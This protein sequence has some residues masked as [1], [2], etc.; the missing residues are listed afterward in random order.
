[1]INNPY[2][3]HKNGSRKF[4][5]EILICKKERYMKITIAATPQR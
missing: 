5:Q 3:G 1:L 2:Q 4:K